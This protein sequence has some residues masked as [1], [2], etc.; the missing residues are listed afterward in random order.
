MRLRRR[1]EPGAGLISERFIKASV[2]NFHEMF[3]PSDHSFNR[4]RA[5]ELALASDLAEAQTLDGLAHA[6][7]GADRAPYQFDAN[8]IAHGCAPG[9]PGQA[10]A[11]V[12]VAG[13]ALSLAMSSG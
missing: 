13:R 10:A 3:N 9:Y 4:G 8:S 7:G 12:S 6:G 1:S 5:L 11:V 2:L